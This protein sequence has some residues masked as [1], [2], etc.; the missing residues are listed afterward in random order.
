[1]LKLNKLQEIAVKTDSKI[2]LLLAPAGTGKTTVIQERV[3]YLNSIIESKKDIISKKK[4]QIDNID[5]NN[6]IGIDKNNPQKKVNEKIFIQRDLFES[7]KDFLNSTNGILKPLMFENV[8]VTFSRR[9]ANEITSRFSNINISNYFIGTFHS[10]AYEILKKS[11]LFV[12][13]KIELISE[14]EIENIYL[15]ISFRMGIA[16]KDGKIFYKE[17]LRAKEHGLNP[18]D[19]SIDQTSKPEYLFKKSYQKLQQYLIDIAKL[20]YD[21]LILLAMKEELKF[22]TIFVDEFQDIGYL[23]F[24]FLKSMVSSDSSLFVVGDDDQSVYGFK[25]R[26][27][28]HILN[29]KQHFPNCNIIYLEDNYRS[30][31]KITQISQNLISKNIYRF[32]KNLK[33]ISENDGELYFKSYFNYENEVSDIASKIKNLLLEI[34]GEQIAILLRYNRDIQFF[35]D[36]FNRLGVDYERASGDNEISILDIQQIFHILIYGDSSIFFAEFKHRFPN[37]PFNKNF[38]NS[39]DIL[40]E[41]SLVDKNILEYGEKYPN[42]KDFFGNLEQLSTI[43]KNRVKLYT[44]HSAKGLEF[45]EVFIPF[46]S[47]EIFPSPNSNIEEERRVL[48][49]AITRAKKR[50]YLSYSK[51]IKIWGRVIY[52]KESPFIKELLNFSE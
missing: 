2:T 37:F 14:I 43:S 3:L 39:L 1:M 45:D 15:D 4:E 9:A 34:D 11:R 32:K 40:K 30:P 20:S 23:E 27:K 13:K 46:L 44:I 24:L 36:E 29:F 47:E 16:K 41:L 48:Y 35:V 19:I 49:V 17:I 5:D 38:N 25:N 42:L 21:D 31:K 51:N 52:T 50:V 12:D 7:N 18:Q 33:I 22:N 10:L 6:Q 26:S 8:I 28:S